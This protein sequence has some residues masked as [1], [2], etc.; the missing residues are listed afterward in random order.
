MRFDHWNFAQHQSNRIM[1]SAPSRRLEVALVALS[2]LCLGGSFANAQGQAQGCTQTVFAK[3]VALDQAFYVNR[4]G[5]LQAGGM[6]FALERDVV[7]MDG[8]NTLQ[9]G[10]VMVRPDKRPRPLT[11][12]VN[13]G[14]CLEIQFQ[15]LL[16][17]KPVS[18]NTE[19]IPGRP[20]NGTIPTLPP[21]GYRPNQ[22]VPVPSYDMPA[23]QNGDQRQPPTRYAGVH[24]AGLEWMNSSSDDGT[25][26]GAN[27]VAANDTSGTARLSGVV[28]PGQRMTYTLFASEEGAFLLSSGGATTGDRLGFG[29]HLSEGLFGS[30]IVEP[31]SAEYYRSQVTRADLDAATVRSAV[32][33]EGWRLGP[34]GLSC[35]SVTGDRR[36]LRELTRAPKDPRDPNRGVSCVK[37][38]GD[39]FVYTLGDQP[40]STTTP[41]TAR[42]HGAPARQCCR[43]SP[44]S[45]ATRAVSS[46]RAT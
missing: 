33:P 43:C 1:D 6:V 13:K 46:S 19:L 42:R 37:V 40:I 32:L 4:Y 12:R 31:P 24:V 44:A 26:V 17:P 2:M 45:A 25:F 10:K 15:N 21:G 28:P 22:Q 34:A 18:Q 30:V 38:M 3:V 11:L 36:A 20:Q 23:D 5:T 7:S 8:S 27:D 41:C 35:A 9:P 29:S 39:G 16:S 14:Q